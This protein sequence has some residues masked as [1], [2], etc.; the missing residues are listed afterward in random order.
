MKRYSLIKPVTEKMLDQIQKFCMQSAHDAGYIIKMGA[1]PER[2]SV[3]G[4]TK[5]DQTYAEVSEKEKQQL[6]KE[7]R[8]TGSAQSLWQEVRTAGK[9]KSLCML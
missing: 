4:N 5:Y 6:R 1:R 2:V 7:F 3:I 8:F 9:K